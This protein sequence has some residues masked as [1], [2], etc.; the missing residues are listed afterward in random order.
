MLPKTSVLFAGDYGTGR[1]CSLVVG[2]GIIYAM[3]DQLNVSSLNML[4]FALTFAA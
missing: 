1:A 2:W 4:S 3:L